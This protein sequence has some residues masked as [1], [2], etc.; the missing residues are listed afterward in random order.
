MKMKINRI[1][2]KLSLFASFFVL[3][4]IAAMTWILLQQGEQLMISEM[5]IRSIA[6]ARSAGE[7]IYPQLDTF[8]LHF[9]THEML[10]E[11]GV[12]YAVILDARSKILSH[13]DPQKIGAV[14][15]GPI[16]RRAAESPTPIVQQYS[17]RG[18]SYFDISAPVFSGD[19]RTGTVHIGS[20]KASV[21]SSLKDAKRK[22]LAIAAAAILL[23]ML[24]TIFIVGWML[25][26]LPVL[27]KAAREVGEGRLDMQ[28]RFTMKDEIGQL[29]EAFNQMIVSLR[30]KEMIRSTFG[31]YM[32]KEV[33]DGFLNGKVSLELGGGELKEMTVLMSDIRGFTEFSEK[34]PPQE[35]V[36]LLNR[37]FTEMVQ[38]IGANGGT[39]DKFIGDA[40]LA[41]FGWPLSRQEHEKLAVAA[42]LDMK[43]RLAVLNAALVKEGRKPIAIGIAIHSGK[44]VAG[45]I[46]SQ[47]KV[48]Y[49]IIGDAV[50]V[51]SRMESANKDYGTDLIVSQPVYLATGDHYEFRDIG[52]KPIRGRTEPVHI[53]QVLGPKLNRS[54]P[55][56]GNRPEPA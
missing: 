2:L 45:N 9:N 15:G 19:K 14:D 30:E 49:T 38:A 31:R 13:T 36:N 53:Y 55:P 35:V 6:Y 23:D 39:V 50:N 10:K 56:G 18:I 41:V 28:I 48:Q 24:G 54:A 20:T 27:A 22:V 33:V 52:E 47:E 5:K 12:E 34:L 11:K 46:G 29:T 21:A 4:I 43:A 51:A 32:S 26:P 7:A 40:I 3:A 16:A 17:S 42:A 1:A 37:Y 44:A 8:T 25:R